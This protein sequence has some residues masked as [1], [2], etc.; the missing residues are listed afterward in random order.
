MLPSSTSSILLSS[1][2]SSVF[3][4]PPRVT[5]SGLFLLFLCLR[6]RSDMLTRIV[7]INNLYCT[8]EGNNRQFS[9]GC[10]SRNILAKRSQVINGHQ[11]KSN[12]SETYCL[13]MCRRIVR[14]SYFIFESTCYLHTSTN[15]YISQSMQHI[16]N[17]CGSNQEG[18]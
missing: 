17:H 16:I 14:D 3:D 8:S 7:L 12:S 18:K 1:F 15:H 4:S 2:A 6:R 5:L 10:Q 13:I 9:V 11:I